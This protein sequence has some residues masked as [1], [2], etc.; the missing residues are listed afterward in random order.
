ML[1]EEARRDG[2]LQHRCITHGIRT[3]ESIADRSIDEH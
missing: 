1:Q 2:P 3:R